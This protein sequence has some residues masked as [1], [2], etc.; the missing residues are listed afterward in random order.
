MSI[1]ATQA[2][3][4]L[5]APSAEPEKALTADQKTQKILEELR[6]YIVSDLLPQLDKKFDHIYAKQNALIARVDELVR[7]VERVE[8]S[9]GIGIAG[10]M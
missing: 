3:T 8:G 9:C 5:P 7:R 2:P 4:S 6:S 1:Q 10:G